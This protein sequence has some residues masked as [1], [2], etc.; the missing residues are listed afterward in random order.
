MKTFDG[1]L[2]VD[3]YRD[4]ATG[5]LDTDERGDVIVEGDG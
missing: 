2:V 3:S 5:W 4:H 1:G